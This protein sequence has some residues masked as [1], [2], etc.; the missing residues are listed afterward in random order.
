MNVLTNDTL[1]SAMIRCLEKKRYKV[2]V[3]FSHRQDLREF[4]SALSQEVKDMPGVLGV[5]CGTNSGR[6]VF[7]NGSGIELLPFSE[8]IRGVK[9]HD[10]LW[11]SLLDERPPDDFRNIVPYLVIRYHEDAIPKMPRLKG[12]W[13]METET[14]E[15]DKFLLGLVAR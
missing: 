9:C 12:E 15:L 14:P 2:C 8:S 7:E 1:A 5:T 11:D 10:V 13:Y 4:A 3:L 6:V